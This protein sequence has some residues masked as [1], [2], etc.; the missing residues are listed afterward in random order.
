MLAAGAHHV[1]CSGEV[2]HEVLERFVLG[3]RRLDR[4]LLRE[5]RVEDVEDGIVLDNSW[6]V[7]SDRGDSHSFLTVA[8]KVGK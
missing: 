7:S 1:A 6:K 3:Q 8:S 5:I 4:D 2:D